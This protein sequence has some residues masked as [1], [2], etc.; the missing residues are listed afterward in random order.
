MNIELDDT[1]LIKH[2]RDPETGATK[3]LRSVYNID[4]GERR[5]IVE[6]KIPGLEG[7][8]LQDL[9]R[10]PVRI[11]FDGVFFGEAAKG[12]LERLRSKFK[13]GT[14][15]PFNSDISGAAEVTQVLIEDLSIKDVAGLTNRYKYSIVLRE[16]LVPSEPVEEAPP[17]QEEEAEEEVQQR[18]D[19]AQA[20]VNCVSGKVLDADGNPQEGVDVKIKWDKGELTIKT[21]AEGIYKKDDL[22]PGKYTVTVDA[23]GYEDQEE[24]VEIKSS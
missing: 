11:S 15:V 8:I 6:H 12:N 1:P 3:D 24:E 5:S 23:E 18:A 4:T 9:G 14:P 17:S 22:E 10:E 16:Y 7:G 21:D 19:D 2:V 13:M 20:S